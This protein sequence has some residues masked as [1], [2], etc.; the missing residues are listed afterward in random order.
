MILFKDS[1][2]QKLFEKQGFVIV[3]IL[4]NKEINK[5][6]ELFKNSHKEIAKSGMVLGGLEDNISFKKE[7]SHNI[8]NI[9]EKKLNN[10]FTNYVIQSSSFVYKAVDKKNEFLP[11]QDWTMVNEDRYV[12]ANCWV[13]LVDINKDNGAVCVLP[14]SHF[15]N[16]PIHRSHSFGYYFDEHRDIVHKYLVP[17]FL[18]AG[19]AII[20][21]HSLIHYSLPNYSSS[22]R[23]VCITAI[24]NKNAPNIMYFKNNKEDKEMDIYEMPDDV[25]YRFSEFAKNN[26]LVP[27]GN[28]IGTISYSIPKY[29][30]AEIDRLFKSMVMKSGYCKNNSEVRKLVFK[31]RLNT[32]LRKFK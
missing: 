13:P 14:G 8:I 21:N 31:N 22:I 9:I 17:I 26:N 4:D 10:I 19:E 16:H 11:H 15:L 30:K 29:D 5:L 24:K 3:H 27:Y 20:L 1:E 32:V 25:K 7:V 6:L 18:K 12:S 2:M 28:K 23:P